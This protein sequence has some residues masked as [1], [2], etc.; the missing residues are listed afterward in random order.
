MFKKRKRRKLT[1]FKSSYQRL[2]EW[3]HC[4][5]I[6][7]GQSSQWNTINNQ[8]R[9]HKKIKTKTSFNR[10]CNYKIL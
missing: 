4:T 2:D 8:T 7:L 6:S 5:C 9:S 10:G 3:N 1:M